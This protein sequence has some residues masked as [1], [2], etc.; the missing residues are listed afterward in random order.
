MIRK[1]ILGELKKKKTQTIAMILMLGFTLSFLLVSILLIYSSTGLIKD[2]VNMSNMHSVLIWKNY[3]K[4]DNEKLNRLK[5]DIS[6]V[7]NVKNYDV[8]SVESNHITF[9]N[10]K[11]VPDSISCFLIPF[12]DEY[13]KIYSI[14]KN[15]DIILSMGEIAVPVYLAKGLGL[16]I[17]DRMS[18]DINNRSFDFTVKYIFKDALF[19]SEYI[20]T[21]RLVIGESDMMNILTVCQ[22]ENHCSFI[23][24]NLNEGD[25]TSA[26]I[27]AFTEY[28]IPI[29]FSLDRNLI[30]Q[31]YGASNGTIA[32]LF[33]VVALF[34][35]IIL[36]L[37][38]RYSIHT[39][40]EDEYLY[41]GMMKAI[42]FRNKQIISIYVNKYMFINICGLCLGA[43]LGAV[44]SR[45]FLGNYFQMIVVESWLKTAAVACVCIVFTG[46]G[47]MAVSWLYLRRIRGLSPIEIKKGGET[48]NN[49]PCLHL[50][51]RNASQFRALLVLAINDLIQ[52]FRHFIKIT[53]TLMLCFALL[54]SVGNLKNTIAG[55]GFLKYFG[56]TVGDLYC[57]LQIEDHQTDKIKEKVAQLN[58]ELKNNHE[59][60]VL[61]IDFYADSRIVD[62]SGVSS[63]ITALKSAASTEEFRYIRGSAPKAEYEI[64]LTNVLA[65]RYGLDI[66]DRITMEVEGRAGE[67]KITAVNQALYNMG[68]IILLSD[69]YQIKSE[70]ITC[71]VIAFI[72]ARD[73]NAEIAHLQNKYEYMRG[74]TARE[75]ID[76]FTGNMIE[77]I[78]FAIDVLML[79]VFLF[80]AIVL[81]L[82]NKMLC[83]KDSF[84]LRQ[85]YD[86]GADNYFLFCYQLIKVTV[87][88]LMS[89]LSGTLCAVSL[90]RLAV[91]KL[92]SITGLAR[93]ILVTEP[94][95][96]F[97]ILPFNFLI[98]TIFIT[99]V[100][101]GR[102]IKKHSFKK[103]N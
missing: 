32:V 39:T 9:N 50:S 57:D 5:K 17:N 62:S 72:D 3:E 68:E 96:S 100:T 101:Q 95:Q 44:C 10:E 26:L 37:V 11:K 21:K 64:G 51:F 55:D 19:G 102:F 7:D 76:K 79:F 59:K 58:E 61:G 73:K 53:A 93:F 92:F 49:M 28:D 98:L 30:M 24:V 43:G 35:G 97:V 71:Q 42:G 77:Q 29:I 78:I 1:L 54:V 70:R 86:I 14:Y 89:V 47:Y 67:Y 45:L 36:F 103:E 23:G 8:V 31:I 74:L 2:F 69:N 87:L 33:L 34:I 83:F 91:V 41:I 25:K 65:Q 63:T 94:F 13:N 4:E 40:V 16:G 84:A 22:P 90:G 46:T 20:S 66:G 99:A 60:A 18:I 38:Q 75:V 88:I 80:A 12:D 56:L 48:R 15:E 6:Y 52:N 81:I 82:F 27:S 85:L